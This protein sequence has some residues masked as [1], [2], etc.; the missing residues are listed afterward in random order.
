MT[1]PAVERYRIT[2]THLDVEEDFLEFV[3]DFIED[4]YAAYMSWLE[5][6]EDTED[7]RCEF[8]EADCLFSFERWLKNRDT[9][10]VIIEEDS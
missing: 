9:D 3:N 8:V 6:D 5:D 10:L 1:K 4:N 7:R 2:Y